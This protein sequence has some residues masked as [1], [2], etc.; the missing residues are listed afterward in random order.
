M[1]QCAREGEGAQRAGQGGLATCAATARGSAVNCVA[2]SSKNCRGLKRPS[3][4]RS[5]GAYMP[6]ARR[7]SIQL[8]CSVVHAFQSSKLTPPTAAPLP[9]KQPRMA[10]AS[11][12]TLRASVLPLMYLWYPKTLAE[13]L[14][15]RLAFG[16]AP[17]RTAP[18]KPSEPRSKR[19][20]ASRAATAPRNAR[21]CRS[22]SSAGSRSTAMKRS[23][24]AG[25]SAE[26]MR[27][28]AQRVCK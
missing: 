13:A 24:S 9:R 14:P 8:H 16:A 6:Q 1:R 11:S 25:G 2:S 4:P 3:Q 27:L 21:Q 17:R 22:A 7:H 20:G 28:A 5:C 18:G 15:A 23:C 10:V 19:L 12:R 26:R